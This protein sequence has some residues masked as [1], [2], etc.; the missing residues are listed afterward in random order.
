MP[1]VDLVIFC[2]QTCFSLR[3][4]YH[5]EANCHPTSG[6]SRPTSDMSLFLIPISIIQVWLI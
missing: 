2:H 3:L 4:P 5:S 1:K 6:E